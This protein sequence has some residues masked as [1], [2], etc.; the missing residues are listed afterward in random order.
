M[1]SSLWLVFVSLRKFKGVPPGLSGGAHK[2]TVD[3]DRPPAYFGG[4]FNFSGETMKV[5]CPKCGA[6]SV[7]GTEAAEEPLIVCPQC[8]QAFFIK[9]PPAEDVDLPEE[10]EKEPP[11]TDV[12]VRRRQAKRYLGLILILLAVVIGYQVSQAVLK[13]TV[14]KDMRNSVA[15]SVIKQVANAQEAYYGEHDTYSTSLEDLA[16]YFT[17]SDPVV[18]EITRA[19]GESW[20]GR[21]W[22]Q[23]SPEALVFDSADGGLQPDPVKRPAP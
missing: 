14:I 8:S 1:L 11:L 4:G 16:Q 15:K 10:P 23:K 9:E 2:K 7:I 3:Q 18:V 12:Y 22:H 17:W 19:D 21:A 13:A 6:V 20:R 5:K